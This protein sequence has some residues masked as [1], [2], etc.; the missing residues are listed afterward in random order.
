MNA[1]CQEDHVV[2][3][4]LPEVS[5]AEGRRKWESG[6]MIRIGMR[7]VQRE[8][9]GIGKMGGGGRSGCSLG[10]DRVWI[11]KLGRDE[12]GEMKSREAGSAQWEECRSWR[13]VETSGNLYGNGGREIGIGKRLSVSGW[14]SWARRG[15]GEGQNFRSRQGEV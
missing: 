9:Q 3:N 11:G 7:G 6:M 1:E 14:C 10:C 15:E 4:F 13:E 5:A 8:N 2:G 12:Q